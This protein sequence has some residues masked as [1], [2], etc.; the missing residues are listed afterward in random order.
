M[1]K[2]RLKIRLA[3]FLYLIFYVTLILLKLMNSKMSDF[4]LFIP[5]DPTNCFLYVF[6]SY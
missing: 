6:N 3:K 4:T 5:F 1:C 2:R